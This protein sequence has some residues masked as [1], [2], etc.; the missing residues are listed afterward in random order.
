MIRVLHIVGKMHRGGIETLLMNIY[1]RIDRSKLQFDFV[2]TTKDEGN[3]DSEIRKLGGKIYYVPPRNQSMQ[4]NF[5]EIFRICDNDKEIKI[6]HNHLSSLT[7]LEPFR[8]AKK[9]G[10]RV[11]IAH[12]HNN[13][14]DKNFYRSLLII[15]NKMRKKI[16]CTD[17]F[18]CSNEAGEWMFGKKIWMEKGIL[19]K[20]GI[21][22]KLFL[23]NQRKRSFYRLKMGIEK[24]FVVG[25]IG[26]FESQKN[27]LFLV[28]IFKEIVNKHPESCLLLIGEGNMHKLMDKKI[29]EYNLDDKVI[30]TGIIENVY[31]YINAIDVLVQPSLF[32]GLGII[33]IEAQANSLKCFGSD[34]VPSDAKFTDYYNNIPLNYSKEVW[35]NEILKKALDYKRDENMSLEV[36]KNQ[37]DIDYTAKYLENF[38]ME[39]GNYDR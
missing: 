23:F 12:S 3:Y 13:N 38:Y 34:K 31:D 1:R 18:A 33:F 14:M 29:A 5:N 37:Y 24:K 22:S 15:V 9:A 27:P 21:D 20:N 39:R 19:V 35:A 8:A 2:V 28:D 26:R 30:Y 36:M 7:Y 11:R 6:I 17:F 4:K 16:L 25:F 10:I 32:E